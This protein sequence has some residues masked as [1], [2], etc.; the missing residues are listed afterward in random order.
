[1]NNVLLI[2]LSDIQQYRSISV[3]ID[4]FK[5]LEPYI[6]DAMEFDIR[7]WLGDSLY[8]ALLEDFEASPS[9]SEFSDL[10]N[11]CTYTWMS[12]Q[13]KH[14]GVKAALVHFAY[15]RYVLYAGV[16]STKTGFVTKTDPNSTPATEDKV[17]RM[18]KGSKSMAVE[19]QTRVIDFLNR[20]YIDYPLWLYH[21][22]RKKQQIR[23]TAV[24]GNSKRSQCHRCG[25]FGCLGNCYWLNGCWYWND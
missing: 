14:E 6:Y 2:G 12:R 5:S 4:S 13:Y 3:N 9:L 17:S 15:N 11:G 24:G 18:S 23:L 7:P 19:Y 10:F 21:G 8:I 16:T 22:E 25:R 1:M 20:N